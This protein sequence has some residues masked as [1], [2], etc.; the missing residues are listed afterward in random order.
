MILP[1]I[2]SR[3]PMEYREPRQYCDSIKHVWPLAN[4]CRCEQ[5]HTVKTDLELTKKMKH[6]KKMRTSL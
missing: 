3:N 5:S 4:S 6:N 2:S 1:N